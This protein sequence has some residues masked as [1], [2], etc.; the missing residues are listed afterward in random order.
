MVMQNTDEFVWVPELAMVKTPAL[1]CLG[2]Q[3]KFMH[4]RR[5][6]AHAKGTQGK[7]QPTR[8]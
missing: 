2:E 6:D 7:T 3:T 1:V 8:R 4:K 5:L